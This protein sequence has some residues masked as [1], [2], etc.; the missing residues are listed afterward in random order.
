MN[1]VRRV[2]S[3]PPVNTFGV[4]VTTPSP[5]TPSGRPVPAGSLGGALSY[6]YPPY[7]P[8][9]YPPPPL[10]PQS[11]F[12]PP[13]GP[14]NGLGIASLVIGIA[15]LMTSVSVLGGVILSIVAA[16]IGL[17]RAPGSSAAKPTTLASVKSVPGGPARRACAQRASCRFTV[18][19]GV[20]QVKDI[21]DNSACPL[22]WFPWSRV[23]LA[24][25]WCSTMSRW[26]PTRWSTPRSDP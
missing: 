13:T 24:R 15:A 6:P 25:V 16:A 1:T 23:A 19:R 10:Q 11:G 8:G 2:P 3:V 20:S 17:G 26:R 21:S 18:D 22:S 5:G 9:A 14:R 7:P 4:R 12:T